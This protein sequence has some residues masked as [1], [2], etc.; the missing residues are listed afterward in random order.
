MSANNDIRQPLWLLAELTYACPLQCPYCS[1]PM[2]YANFKKELTTAEW[3]DVF[4]QARA[5]GAT[6]LGLS[7]GEPLTRP[8]LVELITEA[9]K[10]GFYTNLITSG[11]GMDADKVAEFKEAGLDHIQ[12]SFQA[13]SEDLNDLIAG[14]DAFKHKIAMAKA[15][16]ANGYPMVLCFVTHR[17][18]ID[19]MEDIL[20]LAISLEADYLELATTQ[21]YGWAM[22]NRD[23]LLPMKEQLVKAEAIAHRY[24]EEQQGKMKIYYVVPDY[25]EER[26]KACMNGW[27]N[28]FL[29]I[30]PDGV[31]L[32]CHAARELPGME[33]P[34]IR[35]VSVKEIWEDSND[36]NRFR[37]YEWMKEPCRS[38]DE[39][40]K[41]FG[42]CRC[43]A[44][45]LTGDPASADPVCSKS[46]DHHLI[47]EALKR[48]RLE[49][50][51]TVSEA[52]PLVF[53]NPKNSKKLSASE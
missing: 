45:M 35:D 6:Q 14:T 33:L 25:Y 51:K 23:Q 21:Y 22:H 48:G 16:K 20:E 50:E 32:P 44:Y 42:G 27:G 39:K 11:V 7:G 43:Q 37:G 3:L 13:S 12:V 15:V 18:N 5:M 1:N 34:N 36:F 29:T 19:Q 30:T 8:D 31:A 10:M 41:D 26:P 38:C 28:V 46:F 49:A 53:R 40:E 47:E 4:R 17:Q 24:Q 2:D 9:R 52:K